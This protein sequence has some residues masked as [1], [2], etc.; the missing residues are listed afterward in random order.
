[1]SDN[2]LHM[3]DLYI[4]RLPVLHITIEGDLNIATYWLTLIPEVPRIISQINW[5]AALQ[6]PNAIARWNTYN[7]CK[8]E[9]IMLAVTQPERDAAIARLLGQEEDDRQ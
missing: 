7:H 9:G 1:M 5:D 6:S 4:G 3:G 2:I 8:A